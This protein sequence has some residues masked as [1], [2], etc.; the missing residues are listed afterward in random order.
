MP[1]IQRA[2]L[3]KSVR[4][5]FLSTSK[6]INIIRYWMFRQMVLFNRILKQEIDS[7]KKSV[8]LNWIQQKILN[9]IHQ[10]REILCRVFDLVPISLIFR[11]KKIPRTFHL[12]ILSNLHSK[13][14]N[15]KFRQSKKSNRKLNRAKK[16][17]HTQNRV[18]KRLP[19]NRTVYKINWEKERAP[20]EKR[21]QG[22]KNYC[23]QIKKSS[24][25]HHRWHSSISSCCG[26]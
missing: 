22:N 11:N 24:I 10:N 9:K 23:K 2:K 4:H 8:H 6:S 21:K 25:H 19:W 7:M 26:E 14:S 5:K 13:Y 20:E 17:S 15:G 3:K 18:K 12:I 16:D 1:K